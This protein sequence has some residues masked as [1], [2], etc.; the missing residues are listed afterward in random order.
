MRCRVAGRARPAGRPAG[1]SQNLNKKPQT[2]ND[3]HPDGLLRWLTVRS[4]PDLPRSIAPRITM[5]L[6]MNLLTSFRRC[7]LILATGFLATPFC[8]DAQTAPQSPATPAGSTAPKGEESIVLSPFEVSTS[9]DTS[10]GA[11]NS[12]SL[13][14][15]STELDKTPM[16]ADILT[17]AFLQDVDLNTVDAVLL[18]YGAGIGDSYQNPAGQAVATQP[19]DR[20]LP[21]GFTLRGVNAGP[22]R[23]NGFVTEGT[24]P[25]ATASYNIERVEVIHGA[26]GLLYGPAG[27]GGTIVATT[28]Q[29]RFGKN[30]GSLYERVDQFGSKRT[31]LKDNAS[32]SWIAGTISLLDEENSYR[33]LFYTNNLYGGYG[34]VAIRLPFSTTLRM[35]YEYTTSHLEN[36]GNAPSVNFGGVANDPRNGQGLR[37]LLFTNQTGANNPKTG[38]P[39]SRFGAIDNGNLNWDNIDS[40][41]ADTNWEL[42]EATNIDIVADT[43]WAKWFSTDIAFNYNRDQDLTGPGL[44]GSSLS[45]PGQNG[46]P[47]ANDWAISYTPQVGLAGNRRHKNF[48]ASGL[49]TNEFLHGNAKSQT[50]FG[51]DFQRQGKGGS[52]FAYY[53][54]DAQGNLILNGSTSNLG[55]T[56]V[57]A[58]WWAVGNGPVFNVPVFPGEQAR[59]FKAQ[60]GK[61]YTKM[62][63]DPNNNY[64][65]TP[66]N[67]LGSAGLVP[68]ASGTGF[69]YSN[70]GSL[71]EPHYE[72]EITS[73]GLYLA[74][75]TDWWNGLF[76]TMVGYRYTYTANHLPNSSTTNPTDFSKFGAPSYNIGVDGRINKWLRWYATYS[77]NSNASNGETD[78]YGRPIDVSYGEGGEVGFKFTPL[79]SKISGSID[80][81]VDR[82]TDYALNSG[83]VNTVLAT[84]NPAGLNG[85]YQGPGGVGGSN[86]TYFDANRR[87]A[88]LEINLNANPVPNWSVRLS[89]TMQGG[90][91]ESDVS[92]Q[93]LYNDQFYT[94]GKGNVTY[95][96]G[97]PFVVPITPGT[98]ITG[99]SSTVNPNTSILAGVPVQQL[100]TAMIGNPSSPYYAWQGGT[101][102][103]AGNILSTSNVG[104][105]LANFLVPG[106]GTALT[107]QVGL[108]ISQIQYAWPDPNNTKGTVV[109]AQKGTPTV[110]YPVY[111]INFV[112]RYQFSQGW[113]KGFG[114]I[115]GTTAQWRNRTFLYN[116]PAPGPQQVMWSQNSLGVQVNLMPFYEHKFRHVTWR[117]Q[118]DIMNLFNHYVL[119]MVPNN[120]SGFTNPNNIGIRW[121]NQPRFFAWSNKFSF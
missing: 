48:R 99:L 77:A 58:Q 119:E 57:P 79:E 2:L 26:Q 17:S 103:A 22:I 43:V 93:I 66:S 94:D 81:Y 29:A 14:R 96:N 63:N 98:S 40:F 83:G 104:R 106:A 91:N 62:T 61:Y 75:F 3:E 84:I 42:S 49:L 69:L 55:R 116:T 4:H 13:T 8:L 97:T 30:E 121:D 74:N 11:L 31:I 24:N 72:K 19:G 60:D 117:S 102:T 115:L 92:Y 82:E 80:Y 7:R 12:N 56:P 107:G 110:G 67:P 37:Y 35:D 33:R 6:P 71:V 39:F 47:F 32:N 95:A 25:I 78:F 105:V 88:G 34:Q 9:K 64:W 21:I 101:P 89:A 109:V 23:R 28:D 38:Q 5:R 20:N 45:A 108:P 51:Y 1:P 65:I 10:Y 120:G 15:F 46:N 59:T 90:K 54:S 52:T 76:T 41:S 112:N 53:L 50:S 70:V 73:S 87:S 44:S 85:Q 86:G 111:G 118:L 113:L 18:Q 36:S 68:N 100:T 114:A 16:S 27:A